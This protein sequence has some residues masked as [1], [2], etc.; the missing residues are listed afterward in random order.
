LGF[1]IALF[2]IGAAMTTGGLA[3]A[4]GAATAAFAGASVAAAASAAEA[5]SG[6]CVVELALDSLDGVLAD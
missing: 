3:A 4:D 5:P 2:L 1:F 6:A